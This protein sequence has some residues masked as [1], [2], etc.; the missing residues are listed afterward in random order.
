MTISR[1]TWVDPPRMA[2]LEL[3]HLPFHHY[4]RGT[5]GTASTK[6][7]EEVPRRLFQ[8]ARP[9]PSSPSGG[10]ALAE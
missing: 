1:F 2:R 9:N 5:P 8:P 10:W 6:A 7:L 4:A 3:H